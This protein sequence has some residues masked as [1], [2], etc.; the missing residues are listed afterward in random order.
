MVLVQMPPRAQEA[1]VYPNPATGLVTISMPSES[2]FPPAGYILRIYGPDT[3]LLDTRRIYSSHELRDVSLPAAGGSG[4]V[5]ITLYD[6]QGQLTV[7]RV[8]RSGS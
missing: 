3:R 4:L 5:T 6:E 7:G 8:M 2:P 1:N